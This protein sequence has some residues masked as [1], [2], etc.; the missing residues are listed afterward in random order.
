MSADSGDRRPGYDAATQEWLR[1]CAAREQP[2]KLTAESARENS[3][4]QKTLAQATPGA[5]NTEDQ[6]AT[7]RDGTRMRYRVIR[8]HRPP[9]GV[10]LFLHGGGWV[11]G[12]LDGYEPLA[13][14]LCLHTGCTVVMPEYRLAP[15]HRFPAA[16]EDAALALRIAD[17]L[18]SELD[19]DARLPLIVAGDS[20]GGNLAAVLAQRCAPGGDLWSSSFGGIDAQVLIYPVTEADASADAYQRPEAQ[21]LLTGELLQWYWSHYVTGEP[22]PADPLLAPAYGDLRAGLPPTIIVLAEHDILRAEGARFAGSLIDAGVEVAVRTFPEQ[23]H[24]FAHMIGFLPAAERS[25]AY[26]GQ[27]LRLMLRN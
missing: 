23:I 24:G 25:A 11:V 19:H 3:A 27:Q 10:L 22:D 1:L 8:G 17:E 15:E 14:A 21:A 13:A 12:E 9:T 18:A 7:R 26:I 2:R 16:H 4:W 6:L 5:T 20:A